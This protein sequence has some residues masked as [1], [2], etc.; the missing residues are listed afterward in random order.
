MPLWCPP[1]L[2]LRSRR[3]SCLAPNNDNKRHQK[4]GISP[5]G[6]DDFRHA[7]GLH[8]PPT[9]EGIGRKMSSPPMPVFIAPAASLSKAPTDL[10]ASYTTASTMSTTGTFGANMFSSD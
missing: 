2:A 6:A 5:T 3:A 7:R 9:D 8:C 4:G 10:T 1:G